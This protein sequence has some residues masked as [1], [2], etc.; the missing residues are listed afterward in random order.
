MS[1]LESFRYLPHRKLTEWRKLRQNV[2]ISLSLKLAFLV[3]IS[4]K[5]VWYGW[6][7]IRR[8]EQKE[9]L[10]YSWN[11]TMLCTSLPRNG[12]VR[13]EFQLFVVL[14]T[15]TTLL[16]VKLQL[17]FSDPPGLMLD[18]D[19]VVVTEVGGKAAQQRTRLPTHLLL[20]DGAVVLKVYL[21]NSWYR[22]FWH[23]LRNYSQVN[24]TGGQW[25]EVKI[26]SGNGLVSSGNKPVPDPMLTQMT[27]Y[28]VTRTHV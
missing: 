24:A 20:R 17:D 4:V 28:G 5:V 9:S 22:K 15:G 19:L 18:A 23:S 6:Y 13:V 2:D 27:P 26:G 25:W 10:L 11:F 16:E 3:H 12:S 14:K 1:H 8:I 21:S 7:D